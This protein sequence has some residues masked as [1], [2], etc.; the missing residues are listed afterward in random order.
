MQDFLISVVIMCA[1]I[2]IIPLCLNTCAMVVAPE[3][4]IPWVSEEEK[5]RKV[6][7]KKQRI[8]A[9]NR[10]HKRETKLQLCIDKG[11]RRGNT[12]EYSEMKCKE[13]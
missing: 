6:F 10:A 4:A 2:F 7:E 8:R 1:C 11:M 9:E 13:K 5:R 12:W 3:H